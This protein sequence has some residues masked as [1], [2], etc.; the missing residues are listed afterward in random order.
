MIPTSSYIKKITTVLGTTIQLYN[1]IKQALYQ[2][3]VVVH[4]NEDVRE[5]DVRYAVR[6]VMR[7]NPDIFWFVHQYS[8]Y[9]E[10]KTVCF[11]Y[12]VSKERRE[13]IQ[14]AIDDVVENDFQLAHVRSLS[15][16]EQVMY[17]YKWLLTYC[18][19]NVNSAYN[20]SIDSV[21]VRRNSVCTGY[22]KSAQY[23]F[24][25][26]D[27]KSHLV[28]GRLNNDIANGRHCWNLIYI[29]ENPYHLDVCLGDIALENVMKNAG[30]GEILRFGNFA[31][32]CFCVS[33]DEIRNTRSIE[34]IETIPLSDQNLFTATEIERLSHLFIK[35]RKGSIGCILT[36]IG[37]SADIYLCAEDKNVVLKKFRADSNEKCVEEYSYMN[38]LRGSTHLIQLNDSYTDVNENI[39]AM[40]QSTPIV[41]LFCSHYYRPTLRS[42]LMMIRDITRGWKECYDRGIL[43]RDIHLCNIY[44]A[45]NGVY[46]LGDFGSCSSVS[47]ERR[48]RVGNPWF[49]A[50]ETYINGQFDERSAVYS[51]T[52]VLYFVLNGLR[53][54]FVNGTDEKSALQ[55]KMSGKVLL[56]PLLLRD[57]AISKEIMD[58]LIGRGCAYSPFKRISS[59]NVL[60]FNVNSLLNEIDRSNCNFEIQF[61]QQFSQGI[62]N[63]SPISVCIPQEDSLQYTYTYEEEVERIASTAC[64][65]EDEE[66]ICDD[67]E[68]IYD[69]KELKIEIEKYIA[70]YKRASE[71]RS[72]QEYLRR[73]TLS[74]TSSDEDD[75]T[76]HVP[77]AKMA[78]PTSS[79]ASD[80]AEKYCMTMGACDN[81]WMD[82]FE[83]NTNTLHLPPVPSAVTFE[84]KALRKTEPVQSSKFNFWGRLLK[85]RETLYDVYGSVFAPAE[86]K[87]KSWL[88]IQV[89]LHL[90]EETEKVKM[91]AKESQK[92]AERRDYIPL[93]CQLKKGDE[94]EVLLHI[95]GEKLL[96]SERKNLVWQGTFTKCNFNYLVP[97]NIGV[98]ELSCVAVLTVNGAHVGEMSFITQI[99]EQPRDLHPKVSARQY[100]KIFISYAHQD[101]LQVAPMARAYEAQ[102]IDY[103]FD[104]HYLKPGDIYPLKIREYIDNADLFVLC[105]SA[106]AAQ[107][108]YVDLERR[109]AMGRAFPQI[110]PVDKAPLSIYPISIEPIAELPDDMK[111]YYHFGKI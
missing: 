16:P 61:P 24:K 78:G 82:S 3:E 104:R 87:R 66:L 37:S 71:K 73:P 88:H 33:T 57:D 22:A 58:R 26:L 59:T 25:L 98:D 18:N 93:Q 99:V 38:N 63:D 54:P 65:C 80:D 90:Y 76:I 108:E 31:F 109:Q 28:F 84:P 101:E 89:Y 69:D 29:N 12:R 36:Q 86:V 20:Q 43:Y 53:P 6:W 105:W 17:V 5:D 14:R 44:R 95:Y 94:V 77:S 23:L 40:E 30:V 92:D 103:F 67:E 62:L 81:A 48:E 1:Q 9:Q 91:L 46:K 42:I 13:K 27:I 47:S 107:S 4:V 97:E 96:Y 55:M 75:T 111:D 60:L 52:A 51:I 21:F 74:S 10:S 72:Q 7:D 34:D 68:L 45:N 106:N 35:T 110:K 49:M 56:E 41:D 50:P 32:N 83:L 102:G 2:Q 79:A 11:D 85:K 100:K 8:F 39:I 70:E 15:I 19:Y 64:F